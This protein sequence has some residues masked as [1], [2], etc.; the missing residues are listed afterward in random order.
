MP[1][2]FAGDT[3][4]HF[5]NERKLSESEINTLVA[6]VDSGALEGDLKD[7]P[8]PMHFQDGWNIKPDMIVE[9][10]HEFQVPATGDVDNYYIIAKAR[11]GPRDPIKK[12]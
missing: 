7:R 10:P 5:T 8:A 3:S 12:F 11:A 2:W 4:R 1:P 6:W 9:M